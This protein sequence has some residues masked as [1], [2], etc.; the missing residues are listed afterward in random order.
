[1]PRKLR[2]QVETSRR[3]AM[4]WLEHYFTVTGNPQNPAPWSWHDYYLY[5]LERVGS[6]H[7]IDYFGDH[8]WYWEGAWDFIARQRGEGE[9]GSEA[10]TSFALL[11]LNRATASTSGIVKRKKDDV[12]IAEDER[13]DVR[14]RITGSNP[15]TMFITGFGE[16][17]LAHYDDLEGL[18]RGLRIEKVEYVVGDE[19]VGTVP[20][21]PE[22]GWTNERFALKHQFDRGGKVVVDIRV[23]VV[24]PYA[25][26]ASEATT[27]LIASGLEIDLGEVLEDWMLEYPRQGAENLLRRHPPRI[28][29]SSKARDNQNAERLVDGLHS[30]AWVADAKDKT[31]TLTLEFARA[32]RAN[33]LLFS[34]VGRNERDRHD[35]DRATKL[36][37]TFNRRKEV[38]ALELSSDSRPKGVL[39]LDKPLAV[40]RIDVRIVE[41][42]EGRRHKGQVGFAEIELLMER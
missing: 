34:P 26:T 25:S 1:M 14:W 29:A 17:A 2:G 35:Y 8:D 10:N 15:V 31:P 40:R 28:S 16:D 33:T 21:N 13:D 23:H 36:E 32:V 18:V 7:G 41:R 30:T 39:R 19:V 27:V 37:I 38:H 5:G 11:F 20:G 24:D 9:W 3:L 42:V 12:Y 4:D 6:L 22:K